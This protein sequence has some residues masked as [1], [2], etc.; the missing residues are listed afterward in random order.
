MLADPAVS[1]LHIPACGAE[2]RGTMTCSS[3]HPATQSG[4]RHQ[5]KPLEIQRNSVRETSEKLRQILGASG[6][7]PGT[8]KR[9]L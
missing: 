5:K 6:T 2:E 3:S 4:T 8:F 9:I 7:R 1:A